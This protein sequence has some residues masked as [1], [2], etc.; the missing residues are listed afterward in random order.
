MLKSKYELL[1]ELKAALTNR[2]YSPVAIRNHCAYAQEFL[3][4]SCTEGFQSQT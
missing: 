2:Q 4:Y 1:T 3:E